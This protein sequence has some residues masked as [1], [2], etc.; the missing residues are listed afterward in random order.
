MTLTA[1]VPSENT[2]G[3]TDL[4]RTGHLHFRPAA[5][6]RRAQLEKHIQVL[7]NDSR[8]LSE[9]DLMRKHNEQFPNWF[10]D[11]LDDATYTLD[12][13]VNWVRTDVE[14]VT[15]DDDIDGDDYDNVGA[16]DSDEEEEEVDYSDE[17]EDCT[18]DDD[19]EEND[20]DG[21]H[22]KDD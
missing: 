20:E 1:A 19:F 17:E 8:R 4:N 22:D 14:G 11:H 2:G 9:R 13:D 6:L 16:E 3:P 10:R 18:D 7:R 21:D 12:N 5:A 15:V